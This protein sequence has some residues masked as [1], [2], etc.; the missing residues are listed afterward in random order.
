MPFLI[1]SMG[2]SA[3][4]PFAGKV[5]CQIEDIEDVPRALATLPRIS[6]SGRYKLL[7]SK[8]LHI[9][10][11]FPENPAGGLILLNLHISIQIVARM[12]IVIY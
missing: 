3:W 11:Q 1:L 7:D 10:V 8:Y 4:Q 9:L 2:G 5:L 6:C 12:N